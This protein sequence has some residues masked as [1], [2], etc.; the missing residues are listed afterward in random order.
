VSAANTPSISVIIPARNAAGTLAD[1]LDA[2]VPQCTADVEVIIVDNG[3]TDDT[4]SVAASYRVVH[5]VHCHRR[6]ANAARNVGVR[7]A[8]GERLLFCD[9]DDVVADGWVDE[10]SRGLDEH[11]FVGG[12]LEYE[13][14]NE[15][16]A[17]ALRGEFATSAL[18]TDFG[19]SYALGG[20]MGMQRALWGDLGGFDETFEYGC[21]EIDFAHRAHALGAVPHVVVGA[22]VSY[23][24]RADLRGI[25]VQQYRFAT[26]AARV[27]S[28]HRPEQ[29][30]GEIRRL[31]LKWSRGLARVGLLTTSEGRWRYL[32]WCAN[33]AGAAVGWCKHG[34]VIGDW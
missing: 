1:Q 8:V 23:R 29:S 18:P 6:G 21:D 3:S 20:N 14:L 27:G 12:L 22:R 9:A 34:F 33:V 4:A 26:A 11:L 16:R 31:V 17:R 28:I 2:L 30:A 32:A 24:L 7:S 5:V 10:M 13:R 15:P 25:L 19:R